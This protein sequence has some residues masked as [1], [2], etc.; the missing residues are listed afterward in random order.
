MFNKQ[1]IIGNLKPTF[2]VIQGGMGVGISLSS[3]AGHVA[4]CGG[5][6]IISGAQIGY[7]DKDFIKDPLHANLVALKQEIKQ[8]REIA[9]NGIIGV[10][11]MVAMKHYA[12]YV[13]AAVEAK[14]DLIISGAGLPLDLPKYTKD[15]DTKAV[16]IVSSAKAATII[17]KQWDRKYN[18]APDA[19]IVEGPLAGGHL[20]FSAAHL[21]NSPL[22]EDIILEV[23][24]VVKEYSEK[25]NK[26]IP[27]IAAGGI[28]NGEDV[29]K[30]L[31][32]GADG[33]QMATR[34][35]TTHECDASL[36]FKEAYINSTEETIGIVKS[37]VGMPGRAIL[38]TYITSPQGNKACFFDCLHKCGV[39]DIPYCISK[40]LINAVTG[41]VD[42]ALLFCGSNAYK[43]T[44]LEYV[45]DIFNEIESALVIA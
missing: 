41:D 39:T 1:L 21:E 23:K 19:I 25:Y 31:E 13:K 8:A 44:K 36:A 5:I 38:N 27:V 16:P 42:N 7:R 17:C 6:G 20:G 40:A 12:E 34:F 2:P 32:K 10:N 9:S 33:V 15:S 28:Y 37:P 43:A 18:F 22:L 3:L 30:M 45:E 26:S 29:A 24:E 4:K 11:L 35:V 14:I